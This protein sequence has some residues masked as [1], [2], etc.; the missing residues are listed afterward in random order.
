M[1][2][3]REQADRA[4]LSD[5]DVRVSSVVLL[6]CYFHAYIR[7]LL[8]DI[9]ESLRGASGSYHMKKMRVEN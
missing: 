8:G 9:M 6:S 5:L 7:I 2:F 3:M 1:L 4:F